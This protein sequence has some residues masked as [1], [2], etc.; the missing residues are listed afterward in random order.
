MNSDLLNFMLKVKGGRVFQNLSHL[1]DRVFGYCRGIL[2]FI[3]LGGICCMLSRR[4]FSRRLSR[5]V[6]LLHFP[7]GPEVVFAG[8]GIGLFP[9]A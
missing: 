9:L 7:L 1:W 6:R 4:L 8:T 2:R 5:D 3:F